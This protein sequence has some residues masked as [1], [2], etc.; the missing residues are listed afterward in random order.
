MV[1]WLYLEC[2]V[3]I[4]DKIFFCWGVFCVIVGVVGDVWVIYSYVGIGL[5]ESGFF[6]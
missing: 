6:W 1:V 5:N 2:F 3:I 4:W